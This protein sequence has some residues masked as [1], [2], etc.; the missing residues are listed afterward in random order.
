M[1]LMPV[2]QYHRVVI[3]GDDGGKELQVA[4]TRLQGT[5][6]RR[7]QWTARGEKAAANQQ[8]NP[9]RWE[10]DS[11]G[12]CRV[13][14]SG[15]DDF[16]E[17]LSTYRSDMKDLRDVSSNG[18][19]R[20]ASKHRLDILDKK[21]TMFRN[22]N[23][24]IEAVQETA[25]KIPYLSLSRPLSD[26]HSLHIAGKASGTRH[27][28]PEVPTK[29]T[30]QFGKATFS[31]LPT[32][33]IPYYVT[34]SVDGPPCIRK[35]CQQHPDK[36][37]FVLLFR[38]RPH[39]ITPLRQFLRLALLQFWIGGLPLSNACRVIT[40]LHEGTP[41]SEEMPY[42]DHEITAD[43]PIGI[44]PD[45]IFSLILWY[46]LQSIN[47]RLAKSSFRS[48][49]H[50]SVFAEHRDHLLAA[51][52]LGRAVYN[53][54]PLTRYPVLQYVFFLSRMRVIASPV[55]ESRRYGIELS[56]HPVTRF[57]S[58]GIKVS[59][60][61]GWGPEIPN[62]D[63]GS[64]VPV[65][66]EILTTCR[67][68]SM[69]TID[70]FELAKNSFDVLKAK[71]VPP[72]RYHFR[73]FTSD[74]EH[75]I[76][77]EIS[78]RTGSAAG[79]L[80]SSAPVYSYS[81]F[82][83]EQAYMRGHADTESY[84][85]I[86][87]L[88][89]NGPSEKPGS[90]LT[91]GAEKIKHALG[92]RWKYMRE[93]LIPGGTEI[94]LVTAD[95]VSGCLGKYFAKTGIFN[96]WAGDK[97]ENAV[98]SEYIRDYNVLCETSSAS[99]A[100]IFAKR[101]LAMLSH[102]FAIHSALSG[103]QESGADAVGRVVSVYDKRDFHKTIIVDTH[104]HMAGG[105]TASDLLE[106]I[107]NKV[108]YQGDDVVAV[109][110]SK[111]KQQV[112]T[113][114]DM[115]KKL[116]VSASELT[117]ASLG[118]QADATVFER[119]D[120]FNSKYSPLGKSDLRTLFLKTDTAQPGV[121]DVLEGRYFSELVK[122][123][124]RNQAPNHYTEFRLSIYGKSSDEW[125]RLADWHTLH[126]M[127]STKNKWMVQIPRLYAV[128]KKSGQV[129]TFADVLSNVFE[130]L[131]QASLY[132][133]K[134]ARLDHF[135]KHISGFDSV[136]SEH[137]V[138]TEMHL[139]RTPSPGE[140]TSPQNPPYAYWMFFMWANTT[141]LN[142]FRKSKKLSTLSFRPHCGECGDP[143]H[144]A[145][146]FL[147]ATGINHGIQLRLA[148]VLQYL[149]Y[150]AQI[151]IAVSPI[152]NNSLFLDLEQNPFPEF[153]QRG[154]SV[155]LSTDDPLFFHQTQEPLVEEYSVASKLWRLSST[156][157][158]EIARNSTRHCGFDHAMKSDWGG[159]LY[160]LDS[161]IANDIRRTHVP[162]TRIAYRFE[163]YHDEC[164]YLNRVREVPGVPPPKATVRF[165]KTLNEEDA[166]LAS[167]N[168]SRKQLLA[169]KMPKSF[170]AKL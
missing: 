120:N 4:V 25:S 82:L 8:H 100:N 45:A 41:E 50:L 19:C 131:W 152:S 42:L 15:L 126:G 73:K 32:A 132:P 60:A 103:L 12:F 39:D 72:E 122:K 85:H 167:M 165:V 89:I 58:Y 157:L 149:Y 159:P 113:L 2:P 63:A 17:C 40:F 153:F 13:E 107:K 105:M 96:P 145:A 116:N 119:F 68:F 69:T 146:A 37:Q 6:L 139:D 33:V 3:V 162:D 104:V 118:V 47:E 35:L 26:S 43:T 51:A 70:A 75:S 115:M 121:K 90:V 94:A 31:F 170:D 48:K 18:N 56:Q 150:L 1:N 112:V 102:K 10:E 169:E 123:T 67:T 49:L 36:T 168:L 106:F 24:D 144:L 148:P 92:L 108:R 77:A 79:L 76:I 46:G 74:T 114:A 30:F 160:F 61:A 59:I 86:G 21:C 130:P 80:L 133:G 65:V 151:P 11:F 140:W 163:T 166:I 141:T 98:L 137:E 124:F 111:E 9:D 147:T 57:F 143:R 156:D 14:G 16:H 110:G 138:D 87:R 117:V 62:A 91:A 97:G 127:N 5:V 27:V 161:S 71:I 158:C 54:L 34:G 38:K 135:L 99:C 78:Y 44:I 154:L 125:T 136:D 95:A 55:W 134:H 109:Q 128:L 66:E 93:G 64:E 83:A 129:K 20:S 28:P 155:S 142:H 7:R 22:L 23:R 81:N 84:I 101:R 53:S 88:D 29:T 164:F 52:M